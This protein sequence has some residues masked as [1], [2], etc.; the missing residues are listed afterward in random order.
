MRRRSSAPVA[1]AARSRPSAS[2]P[3][4]CGPTTTCCGTTASAA[5]AAAPASGPRLATRDADQ[6]VVGRRLGVLGED[7]EVAAVVEDAGVGELELGLVAC[8]AGGSPRR[9][10]RTETRAADT[11]RAPSCTSA[12]ASSRGSSSSSLTSSPW[13]PSRP[14]QAEQPLLE[15][16]IVAVPQREREAERGTRDRRCRAGRPRPS[17]R[18]G[19]ARGRA[20]SSPSSG[21]RASSPR[22]RC[23]TAARTGTDPSASSSSRAARPRRGGGARHRAARDRAGSSRPRKISW[24]GGGGGARRQD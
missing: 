5:R 16:R 17:D 18:R 22:A 11:C 7:V 3:R 8:R 4:R 2:S 12:S 10:A 19:C 20:G 15:D 21:R 1:R 6:D 13:L 24:I 9:A 23:P 14:G